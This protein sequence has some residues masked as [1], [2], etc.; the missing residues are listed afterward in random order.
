MTRHEQC[1]CPGYCRV[2]ARKGDALC[3]RDVINAL[4][5]RRVEYQYYAILYIS[6]SNGNGEEVNLPMAEITRCTC[7]RPPSRSSV[8]YFA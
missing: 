3:E 8:K 6:D 2:E 5:I 1:G 7:L 4:T